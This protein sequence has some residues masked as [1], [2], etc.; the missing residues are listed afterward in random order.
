MQGPVASRRKINRAPNEAS[1]SAPNEAVG[2]I[3]KAPNEAKPRRAERSQFA[4]QM[5]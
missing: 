4:Q 5:G 3:G 1:S 2:K